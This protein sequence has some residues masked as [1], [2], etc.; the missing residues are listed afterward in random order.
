M[1]P[2]QHLQLRP[3]AM[4][5]HPTLVA[6]GLQRSQTSP[7]RRHLLMPLRVLPPSSPVSGSAPSPARAFV[8]RLPAP[9]SPAQKNPKMSLQHLVSPIDEPLPG[10]SRTPPPTAAG[11]FY[12][13]GSA[14]LPSPPR[15]TPVRATRVAARQAFGLREPGRLGKLSTGGYGSEPKAK[16]P[17]TAAEDVLL[18]ALVSQLGP[19]LWAAMAQR[20]AGRTG[21]QV[22]ERWLNHLSPG[23][24]K[25][26]WSAAEDA[27]ILGAHRRLG[28]CWSRIAKMLHGRSDNSVKNRFY[29]TLRRRL[30]PPPHVGGPML[31]ETDGA[32]VLPLHLTGPLSGKRLR[33]ANELMSQTKRARV[34]E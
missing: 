31:P 24:T 11:H 27:A 3:G 33:G 12:F 18:R 21:K 9:G 19:G 30:P 16:R 32:Q 13:L 8:G 5:A 4:P 1:T 34:W 14:P 17:W 23:V 25:R 22:R 10:R 6:P 28:N 20:I 7:G 2:A 29:T 26:P 15:V